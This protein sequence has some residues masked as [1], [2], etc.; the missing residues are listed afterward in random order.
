MVGGMGTRIQAFPERYLHILADTRKTLCNSNIREPYVI[1]LS[2]KPY[3]TQTLGKPYIIVFYIKP[4]VEPT[5][6]REVTLE[7]RSY[8][9]THATN[10]IARP[11]L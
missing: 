10:H 5:R 7:K 3:V 11:L 9:R 2:R 4:Y 8:T 1:L 6:M